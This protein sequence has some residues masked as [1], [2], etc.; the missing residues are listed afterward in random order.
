MESIKNKVPRNVRVFFQELSSYIDHKLYFYG[1]IQRA[2]YF[3]GSSDID[4]DIFTNNVE[5]TLLK[6]CHFLKLNKKKVKK[7]FWKLNV[8]DQMVY[9]YKLSYKDPKKNIQA[10]FSIY[11][12]KYKSGVLK[13]HHKKMILP[14]YLSFFLIILKFLHYNLGIVNSSWYRYLKNKS[15][16][17]LMGFPDDKFVAI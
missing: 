3:H 5:S 15:M 1:S 9:G 11:E 7:V 13:E 6:L 17:V 14:F 2:D 16:N 8:N 10:E 12:N 4:V